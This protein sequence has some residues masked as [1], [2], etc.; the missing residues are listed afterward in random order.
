MSENFSFRPAVRENVGLLIGL[1]GASGSGKTYTAMRLAK[2]IC[3]DK[4][5]AVIDTE[6]GRA[7]HYADA[8]RF[9]HGDLKPPFS[10]LAYAEAIR[11][12]DEAGYPVIVVD[13]VSHEHAGDGGLLD[14]H[15]AE[16]ER[17]AGDDWKKREAV[18][19]AAWIKPKA[20]HKRFVSKLLQVRAH[21]ILC[22]R[23]EEKIEMVRGET[24]RMEV[25]KKQT[26]TG[27]DGWCPISEKNLPYELT[28][29]FLLLASRP[30]Y[31]M[32]IK[33]QEQHKALFPLDAPIDETSGRKLADWAKGS[34]QP[35]DRQGS[36]ALRSTEAS[37]AAGDQD[38]AI[39]EAQ[40]ADLRA[41]L[42][43]IKDGEARFK[44]QA[45]VERISLLKRSEFP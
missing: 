30:G 16:L 15:E 36:S 21:L 39:D 43:E 6:A 35:G 7:K 45:K 12:A 9:D 4:P 8:F 20:G 25:R 11:A 34:P 27:L 17:M 37:P 33:L 19:M 24:G 14:M 26:S 2:G 13:S 38:E 41:L 3:G 40:L 1:A 32:P 10:P 22:F 5:F 31:P 18:K 42:E 44:R 23:A 29:S 28:A